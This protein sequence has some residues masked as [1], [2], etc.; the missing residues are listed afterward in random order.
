[1]TIS[2]PYS[3]S[4]TLI[5]DKAPRR[6][7]MLQEVLDGL[8]S[9]RKS[10]PCKY[11]YDRRGSDLFDQICDLP[12]YYPTRTEEGILQEHAAD[13][14]QRLGGE[15]C[16]LI[17]YGSGSSRKT[18]I[19]LDNLPGIIY[20]PIDISRHYLDRSANR[21]KQAYPD[22]TIHP[23]RADYTRSFPAPQAP[24]R[25][26]VVF[27]PGSTIGNFQPDDAEVFLRRMAGVCG[28]KGGVLIGVDLQKDSAILEAAYNDT[29]GITA[30][31]NLNLLHHLNHELDADFDTD[32]FKHH[33][34]YNARL[35]RIEM[36]LI[37][38]CEQTVTIG[39]AQVPFAAGER[40]LTE[41]SYKYTLEGFAKLAR[42][43][44]LRV[45]RA[46]TDP[47]RWFSVQYLVPC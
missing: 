2:S 16:T 42:K 23:I 44:G 43:S 38:A 26:P 7:T 25:Q 14:A 27:L 24:G 37:S 34:P 10:L 13:I 17:E 21:L 11:F 35:G 22:L 3:A 20:V 31:F 19:L 28:R 8:Q 40:I 6:Q 41:C 4:S 32:Q 12:E 45:E 33:A 30:A 29:R 39:D 15:R 1:M 18:R 9:P 46:W 5:G 47:R 36:H